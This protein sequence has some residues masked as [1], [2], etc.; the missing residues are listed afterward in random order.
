M[1][2]NYRIWVLAESMDWD[3]CRSL[4]QAVSMNVGPDWMKKRCLDPRLQAREQE[5]IAHI[6]DL[7]LKYLYTKGQTL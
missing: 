2:I 3:V 6:K 7:Y 4:V 5:P 1:N